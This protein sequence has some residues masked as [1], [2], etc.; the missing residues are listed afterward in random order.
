VIRISEVDPADE[1]T[2]RAFWQVGESAQ[3]HDREHALV[4]TWPRL[5]ERIRPNEYHA[6]TLLVAL[7]GDQA[8]G[9]AETVRGLQDNLHLADLEVNVL[10]D[11]RR[12]GIGRALHDEAVAR[13]RADGRTTILGEVYV[14]ADDGATSPAYEFATALGFEVVHREDHLRLDLPVPAEAIDDL[15]ATADAG[16]YDVVTWQN[17]C[18][19]DYVEAFCEMRT[20]M[21]NDV[22]VGDVD[23]E[24]VV[25]DVTRL[26]AGEERIVR[27]FHGITA[28]ARRRGDGVFG[29]YSQLY[30]PHGVDYVL[31]DDT[32]V[33]P[34]HRGHR[35]GTLLKCATL[36][37]V[38]REYPERV[39]IHTDTAVDN[40][41]MQATNRRF[42]YRPVE[43][44][45][46]MQRRDA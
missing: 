28:A 20:R 35:L 23:V 4:P 11:R 42:G 30:L 7:D 43:R 1:T 31:Q 44:L 17:R 22:P 45:L 19:D 40:H 41:P 39:A 18:P 2:L 38:Q 36:E 37:I 5:Q 14:P 33:M 12:A 16:R 9:S 21:E 27:S 15:R 29:G 13:L 10:P 25:M 34:E 3:R 24:P 8:V 26:R 32:L 46:E 6:R